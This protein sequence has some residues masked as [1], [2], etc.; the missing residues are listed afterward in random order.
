MKKTQTF[1]AILYVL[2]I[3]LICA[4][5]FVSFK[6]I[7]SEDIFWLDLAVSVGVYTLFMF[8]AG[9]LFMSSEDMNSQW[10]GIGIRWFF[11]WMYSTLAVIAMVIMYFTDLAFSVQILVQAALLLLLLFGFFFS[12]LANKQVASVSRQHQREASGLNNMRELVSR[13]EIHISSKNPDKTVVK[14]LDEIKDNIRYLSP[15]QDG[16]ALD[17][18]S[19]FIVELS[20]IM[21]SIARGD[22]TLDTDEVLNK[23]DSCNTILKQRKN[24][25]YN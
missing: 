24:F 3:S 8:N 11:M 22:K 1:N 10:G 14:L 5:F 23:L 18:E 25:R 21:T 7:F 13:F 6:D 2:G 17:L 15:S 9:R 12:M 16:I 4:L 20:E 19:Q